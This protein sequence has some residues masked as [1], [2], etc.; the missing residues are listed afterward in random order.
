[1][2]ILLA[3]LSSFVFSTIIAQDKNNSLYKEKYRPQ[4]HFS[5]EKNW[6]ND[7][8]GLLYHNGEYHLFF[9]YNPF[10]NEWGHMSWGHASSKDLIHWKNLPVAIPEEKNFMIFSGSAVSDIYNT[11]G[12]A[13]NEEIPVVA[14]YTAHTDSNQSQHLAYTLDNGKSWQQY[15]HNPVIDLHKKDFRD[16]GVSWY[17]PGNFWLLAVSQPVENMISFYSSSNLKDWKWL[18]NFGPAGDTSGVWECPDLMQVPVANGEGKKKWVLLTSQ[19][20]SMQY[21]VGEFNG[22]KFTNENPADKI[23][24]PD[25][26]P[27]YYAAIAYHQIPES[28]NPVTIGWINNWN[29]AND[30]PTK[31]WKGAMS[32]PRKLSVKKINDEWILFQEPLASLQS[33]RSSPWQTK[34]FVANKEEILPVESTQFE[35]ELSWKPNANSVSGVLLAAGNGKPLIIGYDAKKNKLFIDRANVGDASFNKVYEQLSRYATKLHL[36]N[37]TLHLHIFFDNSIV[38]VFANDGEAVLTAQV[39]ADSINNKIEL[40]SKDGLN[41]FND[42]QIWKMKSIW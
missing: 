4:F 5:P 42:L 20:G 34:S 17:A 33:L 39:F 26:G 2:K 10:G 36:Q 12:F 8:N 7:P 25:Y 22:T 11:S 32:L 13:K 29:Y 21:F 31:P 16:P 3:C 40:F 19:N 30:I 14:I 1:M 18:S 9:Q 28:K 37:D 41:T 23:L 24:R 35:M 15:A 38:E 6:I 27:D